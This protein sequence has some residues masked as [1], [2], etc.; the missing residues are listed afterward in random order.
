[1]LLSQALAGMKAPMANFAGVL[2]SVLRG[3]ATAVDAYA[4]KRAESGS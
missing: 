4:K 3:F 2:S 1:V